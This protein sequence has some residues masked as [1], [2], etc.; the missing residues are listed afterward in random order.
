M[1][2]RQHPDFDAAPEPTENLWRSFSR[3][4]LLRTAGAAG[5]AAPFVALGGRVRADSVA[6]PAKKSLKLTWNAN[7]ICTVAVPA[8]LQRGVFA[9]HNLDVD[10]VNFGGSTD[11]LLEALATGKADAGV[12][13]ALRWLKPLEAGFDVKLTAGIHG[14]CIWLLAPKNAGITDIASLKGKTIGVGDMAGA[15]RNFFVILLTKHGLDPNKDVEWRQFPPDLLALAIQKG[16]AHAV[17][18]A[19]PIAYIWKKKYDL[20]EIAGNLTGDYAHRV[21]CVLGIRGSLIRDDLPTARGL[22]QA[23]LESGEW[24][25]N[26][27][28]AAAQIFSK[29]STASIA[30]LSA[31]LRAHTHH[32]HPIGADFKKEIALYADELKLVSVMK[33]STDSAKYA[34]RVYADVLG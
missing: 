29:Y 26:N 17:S 34:N 10:L 23:L 20:V 15:D 14:G 33:A 8:A 32:H 12:G 2:E 7:A 13:M 11:Q 16:E 18:T 1:S 3:R 31:M 22:T 27:P 30:D 25:A 5:I 9:K 19:D 24:V 21:C 28:D 6:A 4:T